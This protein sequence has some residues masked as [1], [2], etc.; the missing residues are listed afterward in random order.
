MAGNKLAKYIRLSKED[1]DVDV[2]SGKTESNSVS[3]Q[4]KILTDYY[5][6]HEELHIYEPIEFVD[7]GYTGTSFER[8]QF[9]AMLKMVRS[10]EIRCIIIKDLSRLGRNYLEAGN[11]L[12]MILPLY[13]TRFISVTDN[14]DTERFKGSTGGMDVALRNL[15]NGLYSI[16]LSKKVRS[17]MR[18]K[19]RRG[20]YWGGS[21]FYGYR[22]DPQNKQHLVVD[23]NVRPIVEMIFRDCLNGMT[24]RQIAQKLNFL[25]V[26]S[27]SVYKRQTGALYNGRTTEEKPVWIQGVIRRILTDERYTG[28]MVS[29]TREPERVGS[30]RRIAVPR[31][32]W[33]VV[34]NTH[35]AIIS[36]EVF[37]DVQRILKSRQRGHNLTTGGYRKSSIFVCGYCG[38]RLQKRIGS[39]DN[40]LCCPKASTVKG[41]PCEL[42]HASASKLESAILSLFHMLCAISQPDEATS[43]PS[44]ESALS[45]VKSDRKR[46]SD[47][48]ARIASRKTLL[49]EKYR[50][51]N[52]TRE[53]YRMIQ[54]EETEN[55]KKNE[56]II[57]RCDEE[58]LRILEAKAVAEIYDGAGGITLN[59]YD[60]DLI[61][62]FIQEVRVFG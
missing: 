4:R 61:C 49:Y 38:R 59:H 2:K 16:D 1:R 26:P 41:I 19:N 33:I 17:A 22:I 15:I 40:Y 18:T 3:N 32:D 28:K 13:G 9:D 46:A 35:E 50:S 44:H 54:S 39:A 14:F 51:G 6:A 21:A 5:N 58:E 10:G 23:E 43:L 48:I 55:R 36:D 57:R 52:L 56:E 37:Q 8:P 12:D 47:E 24:Q 20:D 45:H 30:K 34:P 31:E 27:P 11:Y 62:E 7:D 42:I 60:P 53:A 29:Y 25:G